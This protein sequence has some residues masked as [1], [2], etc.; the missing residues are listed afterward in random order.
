[1]EALLLVFIYF[2]NT[3]DLLIIKACFPLR[4]MIKNKINWKQMLLDP[5]VLETDGKLKVNVETPSLIYSVVFLPST[6]PEHSI[7]C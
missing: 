7:F 1:M 4:K 3:E 6:S 2:L 5:Q